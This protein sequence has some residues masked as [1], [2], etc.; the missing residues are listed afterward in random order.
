MFLEISNEVNWSKI[1]YYKRNI[2]L[3]LDKKKN[4]LSLDDRF[5]LWVSTE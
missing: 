3:H 2:N 4:V 1:L 5:A